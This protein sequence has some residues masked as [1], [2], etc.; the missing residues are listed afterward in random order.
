MKYEDFKKLSRKEK[1]AYLKSGGLVE[2]NF[3]QKF[4]ICAKF[5]FVGFFITWGAYHLMTAPKS[6]EAQRQ[7]LARSLTARCEVE[8]ATYLQSPDTLKRDRAQSVTRETV[9]QYET[10]FVFTAK[11]AFGVDMANRA[12]C[13]FTKTSGEASLY[14]IYINGKRV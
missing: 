9:K 7:E 1:K 4:W 13:T 8:V 14:R 5:S 11:N 6:P 3:T 12:K 2:T 10:E